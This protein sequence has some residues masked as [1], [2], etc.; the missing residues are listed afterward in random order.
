VKYSD[1]EAL[2]ADALDNIFEFAEFTKQTEHLFDDS[3]NVTALHAFRVAWF[4]LEIVN[5]TALS[6]WETDGRPE[7]WDAK[8]KGRFLSDA[9]ETVGM[10]KVAAQRL[11]E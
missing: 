3:S 5:A 8:W 1:F 11:L 6:E 4:E 10:V 7:N 9:V 2:A